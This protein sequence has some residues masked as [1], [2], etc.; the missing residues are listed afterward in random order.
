MKKPRKS[1]PSKWPKVIGPQFLKNR[2][3]LSYTSAIK[4][5]LSA[6]ITAER[7]ARKWPKVR[8]AA[9]VGVDHAEIC[10]IENRPESCTL[11]RLCLVLLVLGIKPILTL[12]DTNAKETGITVS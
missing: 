2:E 5:K 3:R 9:V 6:R 1:Y 10:R 12:E 8:M 7:L 4:H 11:D